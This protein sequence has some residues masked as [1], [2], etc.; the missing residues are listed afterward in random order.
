MQR[1][2]L[3]AATVMAWRNLLPRDVRWA[4]PADADPAQDAIAES[5]MDELSTVSPRRC[6][7][8]MCRR[9][10]DVVAIGAARRQRIM[11]WAIHRG[12]EHC[13]IIA[14]SFVDAGDDD[15]GESG[16]SKIA[17]LFKREFDALAGTGAAR[18][19]HGVM[20]RETAVTLIQSAQRY[21][22]EYGHGQ[23]GGLS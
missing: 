15:K 3:S 11:C 6:F 20:C 14:Q 12:W 21:E 13:H 2:D 23:T 16:R 22:N 1:L 19:V 9:A 5:L 7:E 18:C 17:P 4:V 10:D 8:V